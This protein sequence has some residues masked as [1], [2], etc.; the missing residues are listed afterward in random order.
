MDF[1]LAAEHE[2]VR[3]QARSF[4]DREIR[5]HI[6]EWDRAAEFPRKIVP[7]MAAAGFLGLC[8]PGAVGGRGL[9]Y[10]SLGL[11]CEELERADSSLRVLVSVHLA[12]NSLA[13]LQW[14]TA[15]QHRRYLQP[16]ARGEKLAAFALTE[17]EAGSDVAALRT[18]AK[19]QN[20][21]YL[22]NGEKAWIGLADM[23][24]HYLV[25]ARTD[26]TG[27]RGISAFLVER[28]TRG[29]TS[30]S[31]DNKLGGRA[32]NV[33]RLF[34]ENVEVA[35]DSRL[36]EEGEGFKIAMSALDNGRYSVAA[37]AVGL[38]EACLDACL[39]F[40]QQRQTFGQAIGHHQLVQQKIAH[41][42]AGRDTGR[43]LYYQAAWLKNLGRRC[44]REVSLAKWINCRHAFEAADAAVQIHGAR[45]Y[46]DEYPVERYLRNA[47]GSRI[48]EGSEEIHELMQAQYALGYRQDKPLRCE[49]P[50]PSE[51][52]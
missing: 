30:A 43:L 44:T 37:G 48:Y 47:R 14:G 26:P 52:E 22:L 38:I 34:L 25:F 46:S 50:A 5:P 49:L 29:L 13:L 39:P 12:L 36:G 41:M 45:G 11:L 32:G 31:I 33:G 17:P 3:E 35:V 4:C 24:D 40:A 19:R 9:D 51:T 15:E 7:K 8:L 1:S 18:E 20:D 2:A 21:G 6:R 23:A 28:G 10:L 27:P 16:Q 42:V